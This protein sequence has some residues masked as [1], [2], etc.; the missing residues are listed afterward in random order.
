MYKCRL[1]VPVL[2]VLVLVPITVLVLQ[3]VVLVAV[4]LENSKKKYLSR[5][6]GIPGIIS[7]GSTS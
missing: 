7:T 6:S 4:P 2:V 5:T 1:V 3:V